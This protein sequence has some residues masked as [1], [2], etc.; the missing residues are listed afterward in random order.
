MESLGLASIA[1][2]ALGGALGAMARFFLAGFVGR[3]V[4]ETFPWGTLAVN[5]SGAFAIGVVAAAAASSAVFHQLPAWH[6]AVV[7]MLGSYTTVSA[8]SVQALALAHERAATRAAVYVSLTVVS[9]MLAV[10]LG[11]AAGTAMFGAVP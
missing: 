2:I 10:A 1:W 3:R 8:V 6:F 9:C 4:G 7:G 5:V 11:F